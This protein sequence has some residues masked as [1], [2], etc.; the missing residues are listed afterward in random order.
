MGDQSFQSVQKYAATPVVL[1]ASAPP[2]GMHADEATA[3]NRY[4]ALRFKL[5][6][7]QRV[8]VDSYIA[9]G[10]NGI[11]AVREAGFIGPYIGPKEAEKVANRILR[12]KYIEEVIDAAV[13]VHA[14]RSKIRIDD[15]LQEIKNI[16]M[17]NHQDYLTMNANGEVVPTL[18]L[19][20]RAKMAGIAEI[21]I[22]QYME[23]RGDDARP[24]KETRYK[25]GNKLGA[26]ELLLKAMN[27]K[28]VANE[29][30]GGVNVNVQTINIVPVPSGQFIPAHVDNAKIIEHS[31]VFDEQET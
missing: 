18:P 2:L 4:N 15:V 22:K 23:G 17:A 19:H 25:L 5:T 8:F 27:T 26:L 9:N 12:K 31:P 20:D 10:W 1:N 30:T 28:G 6:R 13:A 14:E 3:I 11:Q 21:N 24:V 16:A 7:Q 29:G